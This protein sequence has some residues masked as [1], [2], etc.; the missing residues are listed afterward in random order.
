MPT[1]ELL[2]SDP[3][4]FV[5]QQRREREHR[6]ADATPSEATPSN[7]RPSDAIAQQ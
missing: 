4:S 2:L 5:A 6:L 7:A 3:D 1:A